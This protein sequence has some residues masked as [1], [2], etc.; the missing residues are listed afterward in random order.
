[1]PLLRLQRV[2]SAESRRD[3]KARTAERTTQ[4]RTSENTLQRAQRGV[5]R[6]GVWSEVETGM[7]GTSGGAGEEA[8]DGR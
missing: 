8:T 7:S 1:M 5:P 3:H 4:M 2:L 6:S